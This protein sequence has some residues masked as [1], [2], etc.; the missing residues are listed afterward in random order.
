MNA[1]LD[2]IV[3]EID[4]KKLFSGLTENMNIFIFSTVLDSRVLFS[5]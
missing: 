5:K 3:I 2:M 4:L 1:K